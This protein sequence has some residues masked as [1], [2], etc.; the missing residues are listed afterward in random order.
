MDAITQA[1]LSIAKALSGSGGQRPGTITAFAGSAAP[2]GAL[3]CDGSSV[4]RSAY[5]A[6]FAVIGT[7][8]GSVDGTHFTLPD[9]RG[10]ALVGYDATQTEFNALGKT[11]GEKT[12]VLTTAEM[13]SHN[14]L[15]PSKPQGAIIY[16]DGTS[17]YGYQAGSGSFGSTGG[18]NVANWFQN[19]GGGGAHNNLQPYITVN[20]LI[21]Y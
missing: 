6:L 1:I 9:M 8:Y 4:L 12:H 11:G 5:P 19:T 17:T 13:P 10:R 18:S 16:W 21:W 20:Y 3:I 15:A 14:H 7:T 2:L